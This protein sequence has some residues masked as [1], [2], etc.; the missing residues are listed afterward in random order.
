W[1]SRRLYSGRWS[2]WRERDGLRGVSINTRTDEAAKSPQVRGERWCH[3]HAK[4]MSYRPEKLEILPMEDEQ[5]VMVNLYRVTNSLLA[6]RITEKVA[7]LTLWSIAIGAPAVSRTSPQRTR[8]TQRK[9]KNHSPQM[10]RDER[11]SG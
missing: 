6:G 11:R 9:N 4:M 3:G 1:R 5:A 8:R 7:G 2:C 10:N